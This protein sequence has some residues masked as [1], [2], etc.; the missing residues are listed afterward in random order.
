MGC[1]KTYQYILI[2]KNNDLQKNKKPTAF[3]ETENAVGF[4]YRV[5]T[6]LQCRYVMFVLNFKSYL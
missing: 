6:T 2:F 5:Q 3:P 4:F 1:A